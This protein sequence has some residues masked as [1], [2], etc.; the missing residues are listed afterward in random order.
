MATG[1]NRVWEGYRCDG[2]EKDWS[3]DAGLF[4][5]GN[6]G[7]RDASCG[8]LPA[9]NKQ[10]TPLQTGR[11][12]SPVLE[13]LIIIGWAQFRGGGGLYGISMPE[14]DLYPKTTAS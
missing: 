10:R 2:R 3:D 4:C 11:D 5:M 14:G 8:G 6:P 12:D 13:K 1:N 7:V 9:G